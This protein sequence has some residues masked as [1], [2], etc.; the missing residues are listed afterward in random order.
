MEK[1]GKEIKSVEEEVIALNNLLAGRRGKTTV[2]DA[3]HPFTLRA[4][5]WKWKNQIESL[6]LELK[7]RRP[8]RSIKMAKYLELL[9][10][11]SAVEE[12]YLELVRIEKD[13]VQAEIDQTPWYRCE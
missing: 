7:K 13:E 9:R 6:S 4:E 3:E 5:K 11:L 1:T 8:L 10:N 2:S 12:E